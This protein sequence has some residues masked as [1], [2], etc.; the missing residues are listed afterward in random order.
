MGY[1]LSERAP[2][3]EFLKNN[4]Y[5]LLFGDVKNDQGAA[6]EDWWINPE[7][8]DLDLYDQMKSEGENW[9]NII[10]KL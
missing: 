6:Y 1:S 5:F 2:Q 8:F 4:G 9:R 3:R 10:D 7:F